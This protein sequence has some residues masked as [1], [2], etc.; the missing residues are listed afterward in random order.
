MKG[1]CN[2]LCITRVTMFIILLL[3][4]HCDYLYGIL[5]L[6]DKKKK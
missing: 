6:P 4:I 1:I 5:K 2:K 3:F